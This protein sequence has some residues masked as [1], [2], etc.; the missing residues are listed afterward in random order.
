MILLGRA[1]REGF[2][3][4]CRIAHK[5]TGSRQWAS[6]AHVSSFLAKACREALEAVTGPGSA[7]FVP[8][9]SLGLTLFQGLQRALAAKVS[10]WQPFLQTH[11]LSRLA[12]ALRS[13]GSARRLVVESVLEFVGQ[14]RSSVGQR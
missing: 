14:R 5:L 10:F 3:Q 6:P 7:N 1:S 8:G 9:A 12:A 13:M 2:A 11:D 4:M